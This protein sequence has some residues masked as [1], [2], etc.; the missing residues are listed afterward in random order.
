VYR[1]LPLQFESNYGQTSS[2]VKFTSRTAESA[3]FLSSDGAVLSLGQGS[4]GPADLR[5]GWA[6]ANSQVTI[7]GMDELPRRSN[8]FIGNRPERWHAQVPTY[9]KVRYHGIYPGVDLVY[10]GNDGK[11]EYDLIVSRSANPEGIR[12]SR[13]GANKLKL[14]RKGNLI[15]T[16]RQQVLLHKAVIY[17]LSAGCTDRDI[18]AGGY[19]LSGKQS[20]SLR[21]GRHDP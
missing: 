10:Y 18:V 1:S 17:A 14:E 21:I 16:A 19:V 12:L 5:M 4:E 8:Y 13:R 2:E 20:G 3:L 7:E 9:A 11:L 15:L 6:G